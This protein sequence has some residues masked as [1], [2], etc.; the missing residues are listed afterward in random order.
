MGYQNGDEF[1]YG[2]GTNLDSAITNLFASQGLKPPAAAVTPG[3][4]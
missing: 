2:I 4:T 3:N 1:N